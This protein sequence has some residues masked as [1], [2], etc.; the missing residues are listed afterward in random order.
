M[1]L[2]LRGC[3]R[4]AFQVPDLSDK[5]ECRRSEKPLGLFEGDIKVAQK[6]SQLEAQLFVKID[7]LA[8]VENRIIGS[9]VDRGN[10]KLERRR[11]E[12]T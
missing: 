7:T 6:D 5:S 11:A 8:T 1:P 10:V 4:R 3:M 2:L 12:D 9:A